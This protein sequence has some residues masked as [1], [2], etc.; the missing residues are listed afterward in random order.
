MLFESTCKK[1]IVPRISRNANYRDGAAGDT[2]GDV[3]VLNGNA[4]C[5]Q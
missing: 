4:Q 3:D 1:I 2:N 5:G